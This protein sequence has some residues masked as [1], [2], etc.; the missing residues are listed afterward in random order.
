MAES[1]PRMVKL[2]FVGDGKEPEKM[3]TECKRVQDEWWGKKVGV[4]RLSENSQKELVVKCVLE[5][6]KLEDTLPTGTDESKVKQLLM[7]SFDVE[8]DD[9][10]GVDDVTGGRQLLQHLAAFKLLCTPLEESTTLPDLSE[11][12]IQQAH[13]VMMRGLKTERGEKVSAGQYRKISVHAGQHVYPSHECVPENM[14]KIV[15]EYN[16][17]MSQPHD[18]YQLASW[19][20]F[21]VV[22]LHP[23]EDGNGRISRLL[24]CYSLMRDGL[25]FPAILTSG[26][27]RSQNHLVQCLQRDRKYIV[28]NHPHLTTLTVLSVYQAWQTWSDYWSSVAETVPCAYV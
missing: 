8:P 27:K 19:L 7:D 26:H 28:S 16:R 10:E 24:W 6:N 17:R 1:V 21:K 12:L 14:S 9:L 15:H 18:M 25:P 11:E 20:H 2:Y 5:S 4:V 3:W 22:S 13:S 23:F